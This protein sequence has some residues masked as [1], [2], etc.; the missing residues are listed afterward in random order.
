MSWRTDVMDTESAYRRLIERV[1]SDLAAGR[2]EQVCVVLQCL[3]AQIGEADRLVEIAHLQAKI[4]HAELTR[5][6]AEERLSELGG[7]L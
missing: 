2:D 1:K 6:D 5:K 7:G 4:D 3:T